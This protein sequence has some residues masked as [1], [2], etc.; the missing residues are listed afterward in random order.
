[1]AT[2]TIDLSRRRLITADDAAL[3]MGVSTRHIA[4]LRKD[5]GLPAVK[6]GRA[7]RFDTADLLDWIA[8]HKQLPEPTMN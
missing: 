6:L 4:N 3:V 7:L 1:M 2:N 5:A 8:Q